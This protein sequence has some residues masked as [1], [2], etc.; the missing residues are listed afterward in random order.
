MIGASSPFAIKQ[1]ESHLMDM[2]NQ[3]VVTLNR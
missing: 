1:M 3:S 2:K